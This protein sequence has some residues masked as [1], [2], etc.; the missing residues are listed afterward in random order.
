[1][2]KGIKAGKA[3][4]IKPGRSFM[5]MEESYREGY[6]KGIEKGYCQGKDDYLGLSDLLFQTATAKAFGW[7]LTEFEKLKKII[8]EI[9]FDASARGIDVVALT[10]ELKSSIENEEDEIM[11]KK[12]YT[13]ETYIDLIE[14]GLNNKEIFEKLNVPTGSQTRVGKHIDK[15]RQNYGALEI[16]TKKATEFDLKLYDTVTRN[17]SWYRVTDIGVTCFTVTNTGG[18][19][20]S[21]IITK[22]DYMSGKSGLMKRD[23]PE[24]KIYIDES[25]KKKPATINPKFEAAV[26]DMVAGKMTKDK[27]VSQLENLKENS[28]DFA[29]AEEAP[30][31]IWHDDIKALDIAIDTVKAHDDIDPAYKFDGTVNASCEAFTAFQRHAEL[32]FKADMNAYSNKVSKLKDRMEHGEIIDLTDVTEYNRIADKYRGV[33][34][35]EAAIATM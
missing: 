34:A 15:L 17:G 20:N 5:L 21:E 19:R 1:M 4:G 18:K 33:Y 9:T 29:K 27:V 23:L 7:G 2:G 30:D 22:E 8:D 32:S 25:L 14:K 13:D 35:D 10:E 31:S 3:K 6:S 26:Q 16:V 24:V 28:E 12:K 11:A